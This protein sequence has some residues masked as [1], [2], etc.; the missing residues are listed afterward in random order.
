MTRA[1]SLA[2]ILGLSASTLYRW[3]RSRP[4]KLAER[5]WRAY[6]K[7]RYVYFE[8]IA[9]MQ[10]HPQIHRETAEADGL[11][12]AD[13]TWMQY[14]VSNVRIEHI[15]ADEQG[16]PRRQIAA[17]LMCD[18]PPH[19]PQVNQYR[20]DGTKIYKIPDPVGV[21]ALQ[22]VEFVL[23][24]AWGAEVTEVTALNHSDGVVLGFLHWS[25]DLFRDELVPNSEIEVQVA[26]RPQ[27]FPYMKPDGPGMEYAT[28][29]HHGHV[30]GDWASSPH[31]RLALTD[32]GKLLI[33]GEPQPAVKETVVGVQE[34]D[35]QME[36]ER[37]EREE[38]EARA[39]EEVR[40]ANEENDRR[41][42]AERREREEADRKAR[43][44]G[45]R[46]RREH[47]KA[48]AVA[49]GPADADDPRVETIRWYYESHIRGS[50][51]EGEE[52]ESFLRDRIRP[53][54]VEWGE[55]ADRFLKQLESEQ[56]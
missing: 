25:S 51:V 12:P 18:M 1:S 11:T 9:P 10:W 32:E 16:I 52:L 30:V 43:E 2:R 5:G 53:L 46:Q 21:S 50:V 56:R 35:A 49:V 22:S 6:R 3:A 23:R 34:G 28:V 33:N 54:G 29:G 17:K 24:Y 40:R 20:Q 45:E 48:N 26:A 27:F 19:T 38:A 44:A 14:P 42:E 31:T 39:K 41:L 13:F 47:A 15:G 37:R 55:A 7:G 36:R 8:R 4:D